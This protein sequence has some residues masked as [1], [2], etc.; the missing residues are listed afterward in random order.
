MDQLSRKA[1]L[2]KTLLGGL[3]AQACF[4]ACDG[5]AASEQDGR[6]RDRSYVPLLPVAGEYDVVVAGG[7]LAG[8][9]AACAAARAGA[10]TAMIEAQAFAGGV[11]TAT[12]EATMSNR[13]H[14]AAG[15]QV[16]GGR[17][18][19]LVERLVALGATTP[20]WPRHPYHITFDI[21]LAKLAMDMMLEE[22]GVDVYYGT[23]VTDAVMADN[24]VTGVVISNRSGNQVLRAKCVVDATGDADVA[25]YAGAPL[26]MGRMTNSF[27]FRL[28]NVDFD[29]LVAFFQEN[30]Q[31]YGNGRSPARSVENMQAFYDAGY[32]ILEHYGDKLEKTLGDAI[33]S[34]EYSEAWGPF[35]DMHAFKM[36][37]IRAKKTLNVNTGQV[38][39][40]GIDGKELSDLLRQGRAMAH[41][42]AAFLRK[43][44]PGLEDSFVVHT[45][46]MLGL[47]HTRWLDGA[48]TLTEATYGT[49]FEDAV[50][51]GVALSKWR[52][53][54]ELFDVPLRCMLPRTT[55]GLIIGSGRSTSSTPAEVLRIQPVTMIV[56]QGAGVSAAV[57][58]RD[59]VAVRNVSIS[60]V[61]QALAEQ[62]VKSFQK[63][64]Q[65]PVTIVVQPW[66]R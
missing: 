20:T 65:L 13:F 51:R 34:G 17:P 50:G 35:H 10:G 47:R 37:G 41:H 5:L 31:E 63:S 2:R 60:R 8:V 16:V 59:G 53:E 18:L 66:R 3:G 62:G 19:E 57:A 61:Q 23:I 11:A 54:S 26:R 40:T 6:Q 1:F 22:A 29:K 55:D 24:C 25:H 30:P 56:G 64:P 4:T 45:S 14:N 27:M 44:L 7:G 42:V 46:S 15:E 43:H 28:G 21:E 48:F 9:A 12:M 58:A 49:S 36:S 33:K 38:A 52:K 39:V 32:F